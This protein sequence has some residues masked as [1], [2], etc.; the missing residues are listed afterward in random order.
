MPLFLFGML[1]LLRLA[2]PRTS[3]PAQSLG[4]SALVP[5][6]SKFLLQRG[7]LLYC[8]VGGSPSA[9][10]D[11]Y[12][13]VAALRSQLPQAVRARVAEAHG[14][15]D[16]IVANYTA[17]ACAGDQSASVWA[18]L[19]FEPQPKQL[20]ATIRVNGSL[21]GA[22]GA[23]AAGADGLSLGSWRDLPAK[24][25]YA[26]SGFL[27]LQA[28][29]HAA[30]LSAARNRSAG[31]AEHVR[32][33]SGPAPLRAY[34][35]DPFFEAVG[36]GA[37]YFVVGFLGL[38]QNL[39]QAIVH[40]KEKRV[41]EGMQMM[42][43]SSSAYFFG[44]YVTYT[45]VAL[46]PC[47]LVS[48]T[49]GAVGFFDGV[50]G[51]ALFAL[52][53]LYAQSLIAFC[54]IS[55][56]FFDRAK[57]AAQLGTLVN[58]IL[59]APS[60]LLGP[61]SPAWA[62]LVA[63]L[64]SS[65]VAFAQGYAALS[66]ADK[67]G[68]GLIW[69][70]VSFDQGQLSFGLSLL[71]LLVNIGWCF[72]GAWYADK[73]CS[74][75]HTAGRNPLFCCRV[76]VERRPP[77][78]DSVGGDD[79]V[80][81]RPFGSDNES[82]RKD[83]LRGDGASIRIENLRKEYRRSSGWWACGC[84]AGKSVRALRGL[85]LS[86]RQ[87]EILALL[88][89]NGAGKSTT[90]HILTG[91]VAPSSGRVWF[92]GGD[93]LANID[94]ARQVMGVCP[95]NDVLFEDLTPREHLQFYARLKGV[96]EGPEAARQVAE[97]LEQVAL[98]D[99][100]NAPARTLS[101]GQ[102]RRLSLAIALIGNTRVLILDEPT[103][104]VD[105]AARRRIWAL[106]QRY[107]QERTVILTTHHM[108]EADLLGDR[109]A[110]LSR[111][112]LRCEG[113][114]LALKSQF[115]IGYKL[116]ISV[117]EEGSNARGIQEL[118]ASSVPGARL[119]GR[120]RS[121]MS[122]IL[123]YSGVPEFEGLFK[124]LDR[125]VAASRA[126]RAEGDADAKAVDRKGRLG[127]AGYGVSLTS[128]EEVFL[129]LTELDEGDVSDDGKT[130]SRSN[131]ESDSGSTS[132][133]DE[134]IDIGTAAGASSAGGLDGHDETIDA[135]I[136]DPWPASRDV[137]D[138]DNTLLGTRTLPDPL[139]RAGQVSGGF[140]ALAGP[141]GAVLFKRWVTARR[142][143]RTQLIR[144]A[145]PIMYGVF[146][147][148]TLHTLDAQLFSRREEPPSRALGL[149]PRPPFVGTHMPIFAASAGAQGAQKAALAALN[150]TATRISPAPALPLPSPVPGE[151]AARHWLEDT[152]RPAYY[153]AAIVR[154]FRN[155]RLEASVLANTSTPHAAP[156][157]LGALCTAHAAGPAAVPT[158]LRLNF[159]SHPFPYD[160]PSGGIPVA[161]SRAAIA[162]ILLGVCFSAVPAAALGAVMQEKETRFQMQLRVA[163]VGAMA[164]FGGHLI[165]DILLYSLS[166]ST[167]LIMFASF[168]EPTLSSPAAV[169]LLI[170][171][172]VHS[173]T[174]AHV[175]SFAFEKPFNAQVVLSL[176]TTW[177]SL[178][179]FG[180]SLTGWS[181]AADATACAI[182]GFGLMRGVYLL[183]LSNELNALGLGG[184]APGRVGAVLMGM[185]AWWLASAL[186][187]VLIECGVCV[188][189]ARAWEDG[190]LAAGAG[191]Y[192][193]VPAAAASEPD[194]DDNA[195]VVAER[196]RVQALQEGASAGG[197]LPRLV[198]DRVSKSYSGAQ[199]VNALSL[200][201]GDG[202]C[203]GLL[204]PNGAGK[205]TTVKMI[206]GEQQ[207][208]GGRVLVNGADVIVRRVAR[209]FTGLGLCQQSDSLV[210]MMTPVEHLKLYAR[211]LG[212]EGAELE[213]MAVGLLDAVGMEPEH[214]DK[215]SRDLSGGNKRK[216]C[217]AVALV[218]RPSL[219]LLDEPSSGIDPVSRRALWAAVRA[220]MR[221]RSTL[222]TTHSMEEAE[223]LCSRIGIL[224]NGQLQC[225]GTAHHLRATYGTD[226][227]VEIHV[228]TGDDT[229]PAVEFVR[230]RLSGRAE[231]L[232]SFQG[233]LRFRVPKSDAS[234]A[235]LFG[236]I[237]RHRKQLDIVDYSVSQ[238]TLEQVF[239]IFARD[240][241]E[242]AVV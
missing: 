240:Q 226:Y 123:P 165:A 195:D 154:T 8:V 124:A 208:T 38:V 47:G 21:L 129:R 19:V 33:S 4:P 202:E 108:D 40:E 142:E 20:G 216:L 12:A 130:Q 103:S 125:H 140:G 101:G 48:A 190:A 156:M 188:R 179:A 25:P 56:T 155:E 28:S 143:L 171:H 62:A 36:N 183:A 54:F 122:F 178:V 147:L 87:G 92:D 239:M 133:R 72:I 201:F 146:L 32:L 22:A 70:D 191:P 187:I 2:L 104:G 209:G 90:I 177:G 206:T 67:L 136:A 234:L 41:K 116:N 63:A 141:L 192:R 37:F 3:M 180:L 68:N 115:G 121:D 237:Q 84:V 107:K 175:L 159:T 173:V 131:V 164:Y 220:A 42:G 230:S 71:C 150:A 64:M 65:P 160:T 59:F 222:L 231:Q 151:R 205:T 100:R 204:G 203:F 132:S 81:M 194:G 170:L 105:A 31:S 168:G 219:L 181:R 223:A 193:R 34:V 134:Q 27:S 227:Q 224:V 137:K 75:E 80:E 118:V 198:L 39:L 169:I 29:L 229:E 211:V 85:S 210:E 148:T 55:S 23:F 98:A 217:C 184:D 232:Q 144:L 242:E 186:L 176:V 17:R 189:A 161:Q 74:G 238:A 153:A 207:P 174:G 112:R 30:S 49:A 218:S 225:L 138:E 212:T 119:D 57:T 45:T 61:G 128:L 135:P 89:H 44:W 196:R 91:L 69:F 149:L 16:E 152:S 1:L 127:V 113:T 241:Q 158:Q 182:P 221:D 53:T 14:G 60:L 199:A 5:P 228:G 106:L 6:V 66:R 166:A 96:A 167:M 10:A 78:Y 51:S 110:I 120:T 58:A 111:G 114:A 7:C 102:K 26:D 233:K 46:L 172:G 76:R 145:I 185:V 43:L 99:R 157:A 214:R 139:A 9:R 162:A 197:T 213:N 15:P 52:L 109:I 236:E 18:G 117:A 235:Q 79:D 93:M 35:S 215:L 163:G 83:A 200:A 82:D 95:Q 94:A 86:L 126:G 73:A 11:A 77:T 24:S 50:P 97:K 13:L 88:G